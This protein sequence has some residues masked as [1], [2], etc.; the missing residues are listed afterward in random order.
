MSIRSD[1]ENDAQRRN[2]SFFKENMKVSSANYFEAGGAYTRNVPDDRLPSYVSQAS[3]SISGENP[4]VLWVQ[5][6]Y[7]PLSILQT[8]SLNLQI[9]GN[10]SIISSD[11]NLVVTVV[12]RHPFLLDDDVEMTGH[13]SIAGRS[14]VYNASTYW[15]RTVG[16]GTLVLQMPLEP[17]DIPEG[18]LEF[19]LNFNL[20]TLIKG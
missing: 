1:D 19:Y 14:S 13:F 10:T 7:N 6:A 2:Y 12:F 18:T 9:S 16:N 3:V 15:T 20:L 8:R 5:S 17:L 4:Q 11:T